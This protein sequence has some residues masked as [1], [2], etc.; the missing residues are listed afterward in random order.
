MPDDDPVLAWKKKVTLVLTFDP[1]DGALTVD[2]GTLPRMFANAILG[3]V[4]EDDFAY[5]DDEQYE[6][7]E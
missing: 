5:T 3:Q 4:G 2:R 1:D 6:E 7:V